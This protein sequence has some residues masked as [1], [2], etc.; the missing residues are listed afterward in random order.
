MPRIS[1]LR[2]AFRFCMLCSMQCFSSVMQKIVQM[3]KNSYKFDESK[4]SNNT[5]LDLTC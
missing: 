5:C 3:V 2:L 4:V 1:K